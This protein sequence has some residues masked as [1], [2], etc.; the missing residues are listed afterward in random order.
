MAIPSNE[1]ILTID[2]WK[3]ANQI[4][5][6]DYVFDQKGNPVK[7][8][9]VQEYFA[10]NCYSVLLNDLMTIKADENAEFLLET[11][12]YRKRTHEYRGKNEFRRPLTPTPLKELATKSL[13]MQRNRSAFSIPTCEPLKFPTQDLPIPPFVFGYW[14]KNRLRHGNL[15]VKPAYLDEVKEKFQDNGYEFKKIQTRPDGAVLFTVTPR[16]EQ[17]LAPFI[18]HEIPTNYLLSSDEQRVELLRGLLMARPRQYNQERD[19]FLM[20]SANWN[21]IRTLQSLVESI[22]CKTTLNER[23][24]FKSYFLEFKCRRQLLSFQKSPPVKVHSS[25]RFI[26]EINKISGRMCVHIETEG[27]DGTFLVGEGFIACR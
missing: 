18:P 22:G 15:V 26:K 16:I 14:Y 5:A 3:P 10:E 20:K 4:V 7:V 12:K 27:Q 21:E 11:P 25:R 24:F 6:G 13:K 8:K 9:L 19:V 23:E 1:K 2:Y 17:Q